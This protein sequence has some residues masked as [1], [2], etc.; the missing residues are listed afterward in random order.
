VRRRHLVATATAGAFTSILAT[1]TVATVPLVSAAPAKAEIAQEVVQSIGSIELYRAREPRKVPLVIAHRGASA[2][3]AEHTIEAYRL[4]IEMGADFIEADLVMTQDG[5][6]VARHEHELAGTTDV[7]SHPEYA[8]RRTTKLVNGAPATGWFTEDFTL[9]ELRT[10][11]AT[12]RQ[13]G[14]ASA[15]APA[16]TSTRPV[17][18]VRGTGGNGASGPGRSGG[19]DASAAASAAAAASASAAAAASAEPP[20]IATL[21]EAIDVVT[22]ERAKRKRPIGLYLELKLPGYFGSIGLAPEPKLAEILRANNL[23]AAG[24]PVFVESFEADS[25]RRLHALS[26]VPLVQLTWDFGGRDKMRDWLARSRSYAAGVGVP[27]EQLVPTASHSAQFVANAHRLGLEVHVFTFAGTPAEYG[28]Y[29][30][31]GV[32]GVFTDNPDVAVSTRT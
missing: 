22:A 13:A 21:Q 14:G 15:S 1:L 2:Y 5:E 6:F 7:A 31:I 27:R 28:P 24:S 18:G 26:P 30:A 17:S 16:P 12:Q 19:P 3:R 11:R 29:F 23:D 4:A 10:L 8:S 9:A 25:L 32:D 20:R